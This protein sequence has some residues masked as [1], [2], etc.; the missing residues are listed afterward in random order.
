ML[1]LLYNILWHLAIPFILL[2]LLWRSRKNIGYRK[3]LL[4]RFAIYPKKIFSPNLYENNDI[5]WVHAVSLGEVVGITPL[6]KTLL[7]QNLAKHVVFTTM[8]P[9]GMTQMKKTFQ[10]DE[11]FSTVTCLYVPY[12][13]TWAINKFIE[14]FQPKYLLIMET[15]LWPNLLHVTHK[16]NIPIFLINARLTEKSFAS[17]YK[18]R[19]F[20]ASMLDK[21]DLIFAQSVKDAEFFIKLGANPAKVMNTGNIKFDFKLSMTLEEDAKKLY[22]KF[23]MQDR[24]IWV[25]ASTHEHEEEI[26]LEAFKIVQQKIPQVLL[27]LV[28]RHPER[29]NEVTNLCQKYGFNVIRYS[30]NQSVNSATNIFIG[31][32]MGKLLEFYSIA[33]VAF[34]GGSLVPV[35]GHNILEPALCK[36]PVIVGS[37]TQT[38]ADIMT[39]F[40]ENQAVL[41][42][43][44]GVELADTVTLYL[45]DTTLNQQLSRNAFNVVAQNQGVI[46][47]IL[48]K[49]FM[50]C[51]R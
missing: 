8:T 6:V 47:K 41:C 9:T 15:E 31:D 3:S 46:D 37:Y 4:E 50:F 33:N 21:I 25:V 19:K 13:Y 29:F 34:V 35:G 42:V 38:L 30:Q 1:R 12:D 18:I 26:V 5:V 43:K 22:E 39:V 11:Y 16:K 45:Q 44:D 14:T 28:P 48:P 27:I 40:M 23:S 51:G 32:V 20:M 36:V 17:Y 7:R 10:N 2:R 49:I 24:P